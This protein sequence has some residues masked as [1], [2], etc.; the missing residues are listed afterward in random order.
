MPRGL[1]S[2]PDFD[3]SITFTAPLDRL[4]NFELVFR[5]DSQAWDALVISRSQTWTHQVYRDSYVTI[6]E[7]G[8]V[9]NIRNLPDANENVLRLGVNGSH[10][11]AY[12]NAAQMASFI[13]SATDTAS[14]EISPFVY[15][16]IQKPV[17]VE[18]KDFTV[19]CPN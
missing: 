9:H 5:R 4:W 7:Q 13:L 3:A 16:D 1:P 12:L 2:V 15:N 17:T 8:G 14:N 10:A 18:F 19:S 11:Y 6:A